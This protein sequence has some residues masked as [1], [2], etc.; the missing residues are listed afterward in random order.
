[1]VVVKSDPRAKGSMFRDTQQFLS[2]STV[3]EVV[4]V[5]PSGEVISR[6][7]MNSRDVAAWSK[8]LEAAIAHAKG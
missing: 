4:L 2:G 3:P 7:D 6:P 8:L 5:S 1:M